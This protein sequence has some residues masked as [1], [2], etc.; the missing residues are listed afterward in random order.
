MKNRSRKKWPPGERQAL[1]RITEVPPPQKPHSMMVLLTLPYFPH[2][3]L[4]GKS[5][6]TH[7]KQQTPLVKHSS[8]NKGSPSMACTTGT[9]ISIF[10]TP[11][12]L[13]LG[14]QGAATKIGAP[15]YHLKAVAGPCF[16]SG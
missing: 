16:A 7:L 15:L 11:T 5:C 1:M 2:K 3:V 13:L 14:G 4:A 8:M 10:V 12:A 9:T 6:Q